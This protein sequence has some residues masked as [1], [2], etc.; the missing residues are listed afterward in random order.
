LSN[1]LIIPSKIFINGYPIKFLESDARMEQEKF[2]LKMKETLSK[3]ILKSTLS[4][5]LPRIVHNFELFKWNENKFEEII[6]ENK[7]EGKLDLLNLMIKISENLNSPLSEEMIRK[8]EETVDLDDHQTLNQFLLEIGET[9]PLCRIL[10]SCPQGIVVGV[11]LFTKPGLKMKHN[12]Q[13]KDAKVPHPWRIQIYFKE[14]ES[15]LAHRRIEQIFE[16]QEKHLIKEFG[17][18]KDLFLFKWSLELQFGMTTGEYQRAKVTLDSLETQKEEELAKYKEPIEGFYFANVSIEE[19]K[20]EKESETTPDLKQENVQKETK[21]NFENINEETPPKESTAIITTEEVKE[22]VNPKEE[23]EIPKEEEKVNQPEQGTKEKVTQ[24]KEQVVISKKESTIGAIITI[25]EVKKEEEGIDKIKFKKKLE[26][27]LDKELKKSS[28]SKDL[29]RILQNF[30]LFNEQEERIEFK[31]TED[32]KN[33]LLTLLQLISNE[34]K[35]PLKESSIQF[36]QETVDLDSHETLN[37]FFLDQLGEHATLT[38]L[39][40]ACS[41]SVVISTIL[42]TKPGLKLKYNVQFKDAKVPHPWRIQ[43]YF[44]KEECFLV[45]RRI[46]QIFENQE[47]HLIKEFGVWKDTLQFEWD[48]KL[49]FQSGYYVSCQIILNSFLGKEEEIQKYKES[50]EVFYNNTN[51][52]LN[53][54]RVESIPLLSATLDEPI[55]ISPRNRSNAKKKQEPYNVEY[56]WMDKQDVFY[57]SLKEDS[58]F[59]S[60]FYEEESKKSIT[61]LGSYEIENGMIVFHMDKEKS[62]FK[63][64][65]KTSFSEDKIS[66]LFGSGSGEYIWNDP[67]ILAYNLKLKPRVIDHSLFKDEK[68]NTNSVEKEEENVEKEKNDSIEEDSSDTEGSS[69]SSEDVVDTTNE[70]NNDNNTTTDVNITIEK[71]DESKERKKSLKKAMSMNLIRQLEN[72]K[73]HEKLKFYEEL[74]SP[75]ESRKSQEMI[76]NLQIPSL[77]G[78]M[79]HHQQSVPFSPRVHDISARYSNKK[80]EKKNEL[81][82]YCNKKVYVQER[83]EVNETVYHHYCFKCSVCKKR[84]HLGNFKSYKNEIF[85]SNHY[86]N[87]DYQLKK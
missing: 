32:R 29:P 18:W 4:K 42:F 36:Y 8:Y 80:N 60:S 51:V 22:Q 14:T 7:G 82:E 87:I 17:V 44:K 65:I 20:E 69:V 66:V 27:T 2:G 74:K 9:S 61:C 45:H 83:L 43:L 71:E 3:S 55:I 77:V 34:L 39:L 57:L 41:Q 52:D 81:C 84:L 38:N 12:I 13:F 62:H 76:M 35:E 16:N 46:E 68:G 10:K 75:K 31:R 58:T 33:D 11:M 47:K 24:T 21:E 15:F 63:E 28:L 26:E 23:E 53:L 50:I 85:C 78:L 5:D 37:S 72:T 59:Q 70:S 86:K 48:M 25:E 1:G 19:E 73:I 54:E 64:D 40:K 56:S 79:D 49:H 6:L 67:S 30:E